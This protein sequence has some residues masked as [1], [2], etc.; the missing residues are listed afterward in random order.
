LF[1]NFIFSRERM[2]I[3]SLNAD[4]LSRC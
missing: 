1:S 4:G 2:G 3:A